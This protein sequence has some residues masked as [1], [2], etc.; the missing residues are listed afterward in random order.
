MKRHDPQTCFV[1]HGS[2][3]R[4]FS[5]FCHHIIGWLNLGFCNQ[6]HPQCWSSP[7]EIFDLRLGEENV[8]F[9]C[10]DMGVLIRPPHPHGGQLG[11]GNS[12]QST[13]VSCHCVAGETNQWIFLNPYIPKQLTQPRCQ[14][15][16]GAEIT[17]SV[18]LFF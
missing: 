9:L 2:V 12:Q 10:C 6:C 3:L 17:Q 1:N 15:N 5:C 14:K 7:N 16:H 13:H 18:F 11:E 8:T 4:N